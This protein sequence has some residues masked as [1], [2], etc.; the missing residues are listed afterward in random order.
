MSEAHYFVGYLAKSALFGYNNN[1]GKGEGDM[2]TTTNTLLNR[3]KRQKDFQEFV[4]DNK[5]EFISVSLND[6]LH[7]L[8]EE[9]GLLPSQVIRNAQIERS[10]GH[11]IFNGTRVP[12]RDKLIQIALGMELSFDEAQDLLKRAGKGM[13]YPKVE[14]DAACIFGFHN[15]MSLMEVQN[16]LEDLDLPLLGEN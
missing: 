1:T 9:R 4:R 8:C 2:A 13:L 11:Q 15:K 3:L 14:R 6:H 12:S 7:K 5:D 10:Y 16:L